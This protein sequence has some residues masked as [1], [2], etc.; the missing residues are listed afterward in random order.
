MYIYIYTYITYMITGHKMTPCLSNAAAA[1]LRVSQQGWPVVGK[2]VWAKQ[3]HLHSP[4]HSA[5]RPRRIRRWSW[6]ERGDARRLF[7]DNWWFKRAPK[8]DRN[9]FPGWYDISDG[10]AC[11]GHKTFKF[12]QVSNFSTYWGLA[13]FGWGFHRLARQTF[14]DLHLR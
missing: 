2:T 6:G 12:H 11:F 13:L 3:C 4:Q 10:S 1:V 9:G 5:A 14:T 7:V 8:K